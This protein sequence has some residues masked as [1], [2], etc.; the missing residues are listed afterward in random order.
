[1]TPR[2]AAKAI[3][4]PPIAAQHPKT[5][6]RLKSLPYGTNSHR[7]TKSPLR[8]AKVHTH[9]L[10]GARTCARQLATQPLAARP[11]QC[12][13]LIPHAPIRVHLG[14]FQPHTS[15]QQEKT[16][17]LASA[18][19]DPHSVSDPTLSAATPQRRNIARHLHHHPRL[20][21]MVPL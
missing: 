15:R 6:N 7:N 8:L 12:Y 4:M 18:R 16:P 19:R 10:S 2:I 17:Q 14:I 1:M 3:T 5:L 11:Q 13:L 20:E 21:P 9:S